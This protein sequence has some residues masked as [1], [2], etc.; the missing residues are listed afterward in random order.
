MNDLTPRRYD[1]RAGIRAML[2]AVVALAMLALPGADRLRAAEPVRGGSFTILLSRD[3]EGFDAIKSPSLETQRYQILFAVHD[4]LFRYNA[5]TG[6]L[7]PRLATSAVPADDYRRWTVT[8]R[9]GVRFS[10]GNELTS[11]AYVHHFARLLASPL[12]ETF[13][14]HLG[15]PLEKVTAISKYELSFEFSKPAV[16]FDSI[17]G[18]PVYVWYLNEPDFARQREREPEYGRL[19]AGAGPYMVKE[20]SL[21]NRVVLTKNPHYWN[22]DEQYADEL[23]FRI[24]EGDERAAPWAALRAGELDVMFTHGD[25]VTWGRTQT[26]FN[27]VDTVRNFITLQINFNTAREPLNDLRVRRALVHALNRETIARIASRG[28]AL[29]AHQPF[30]PG[31]RWY[32]PDLKLLQYDPQ[33][34]RAL[35]REY[36]KPLPR[37]DILA[38]IGLNKNAAEVMQ[39]MWR[40]VGVEANIVQAVNP[41]AIVQAL[42]RHEFFVQVGPSGVVT[43]PT[44]FLLNVQSQNP[45]NIWGLRSERVDRAIAALQSARSDNEIKQSYCELEQARLDE[46]PLAYLA[47]GA[48]GIFSKKNVGGIV[49]PTSINYD[50]HRIY[51]VK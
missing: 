29:V 4:L 1:C 25:L 3:F 35:L 27:F 38:T 11:E 5:T 23:V 16:A 46:V 48:V 15:L 13:R 41:G 44:T 50:L 37:L 42:R 21:G 49:V 6:E 18:Q 8:L 36:G 26:E 12:A 47:Y 39:G 28:G 2:V 19:S 9:E 51:R 17:M 14:T 43:H 31:D 40:E 7:T 22:P 34:A 20:W 33:K 30:R 10:N 32:C 24:V 45:F